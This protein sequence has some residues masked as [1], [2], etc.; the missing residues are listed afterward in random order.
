MQ[1]ILSSKTLLL[2]NKFNG[3]RVL[4][5]RLIESPHAHAELVGQLALGQV[6]VVL[7]DAHDPEMG[8]FLDLGLAAGHSLS[9]SFLSW[10]K[11]Y[12]GFGHATAMPCHDR[13]A[14]YRGKSKV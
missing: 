6:R 3:L 9:G 4:Q 11:G 2:F 7:Q 5:G 8:V 1:E 13:L 12:I 10:R 14:R